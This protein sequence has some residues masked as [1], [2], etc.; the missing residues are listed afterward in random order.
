M[1][2]FVVFGIC[3]SLAVFFVYVGG[4][5]NADAQQKF[6]L[7]WYQPEPAGHPWTDVG[8][9]ICDEIYKRSDGR[10]QITQYPAGALGSQ[11][12]AVEMLRVGTLDFLT[13]GP[14]ILTS[15]DEDVQVFALPYLFRDREHAYKVIE[16]DI[17][18]KMF[19]DKILKKS[20]VRTIQ[21]WYFGVRT[22]TIKGREV[23]TPA[24][25]A[26]AKIR[27]M[28]APVFK[29][30]IQSL[31]ANATPL[32]FKE[33]YLAMQT[34][35]VE[36]QENPIPTIYRQKFYEVQDYIVLTNHSIHMGTVHVAE[37]MWQSLSESD[38]KM[39][40]DVFN[41]YRSEIDKRLDADASAN[42]EEM[43]AK[44]IKVI[45]PDREAF[46]EQATAYIMNVYNDKWGDLI[47]QIQAVE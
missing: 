30:V 46:K 4:T 23:H 1:R 44:G 31:G 15:F 18:Q 9:M 13:S 16:S 17:G 42:L 35:V 25:L 45:E 8:Q 33:L 12:E 14:S 43:Q 10:I 32:S 28:D 36:G 20:G 6:E 26:G 22:L 11:Y 47:R 19:N 2:K 29:H 5:V 40:M 38:R 21:F 39:I 37:K 41:E 3:L 27:C 24:D 34:G 7:K